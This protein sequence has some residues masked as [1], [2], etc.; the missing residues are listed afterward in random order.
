MD[1][2]VVIVPF[3]WAISPWVRGSCQLTE[4]N[5]PKTVKMLLAFVFV[6]HSWQLLLPNN[7]VLHSGAQ[8]P[9]NLFTQT[10]EDI[11]QMVLN[12]RWCASSVNVIISS[13]STASTSTGLS[14]KVIIVGIIVV[15]LLKE[16]DILCWC[17]TLPVELSLDGILNKSWKS[18]DTTLVLM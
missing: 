6:C 3:N 13:Y 5:W 12:R 11:I 7:H 16:G 2:I 14:R 15:T 10:F 9:T 8:Q 18:F 17:I 1:I 4:M